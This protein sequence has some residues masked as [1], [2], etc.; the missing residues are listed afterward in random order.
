MRYRLIAICFSLPVF[1]DSGAGMTE[2]LWVTELNTGVMTLFADMGRFFV[3]R[4]TVRWS[5][6]AQYIG[7]TYTE[8]GNELYVVNTLGELQTS[9]PLGSGSGSIPEWRP[10]GDGLLVLARNDMFRKQV[11]FLAEPFATAMPETLTTRSDVNHAMPSWSPDGNALVW[12]RQD[13]IGEDESVQI[14]DI[15]DFTATRGCVKRHN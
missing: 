13:F 9:V 12:Q 11:V 14:I 7:F 1:I 2:G 4:D 10:G 3:N 5:P 15:F 8:F 6:N